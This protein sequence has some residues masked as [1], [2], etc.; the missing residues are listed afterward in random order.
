MG[1]IYPCEYACN[2]IDNNIDNNKVRNKD[3]NDY[4]SQGVLSNKN[5]EYICSVKP[6]TGAEL[7][8]TVRS[9]PFISHLPKHLR[10]KIAPAFP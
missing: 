5:Y 2:L 7:T 9:A 1:I 6:L 3:I 4:Q 8:G 10:P